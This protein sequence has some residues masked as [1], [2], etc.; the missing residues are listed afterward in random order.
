LILFALGAALFEYGNLL[1]PEAA[2]QRQ[3]EKQSQQEPT[4]TIKPD[5][6]G[7]EAWAAA[8]AQDAS[9]GLETSDET[10]GFGHRIVLT[11]DDGP[12]PA[13]TPAILDVL[14]EHNVKAT[15]WQPHSAAFPAT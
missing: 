14:R 6:G 10:L 2:E 11:F 9:P 12:N 8:N 7:D 5:Q 3:P 4:S 15:F 13:A 1:S